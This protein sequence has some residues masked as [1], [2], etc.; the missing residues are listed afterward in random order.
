MPLAPGSMLGPYRLVRLLGAG[1]MGE[2][3]RARDER[4]GRDVAIK[5]LPE[6]VAT[7]SDRLARFER[8]ARATAALD[9]PNILAV[10]DVGRHNGQPY[11]VTQLLE[12]RTLRQAIATG[13]LPVSKALELGIQIAQGLGAAHDRG[14][15]HRDLKPSNIFLTSDGRAKILDFGLARLALSE[16]TTGTLGERSTATDLTLAGAPVGTVGYMAP[17]QV[18]GLPADHRSDIFSFGCVLYEMLAGQRAFSKDS[19]V[20]TMGSILHEDPPWLTASSRSVP[21]ALAAVVRRCLEKRP[22]ARFQSAHD[23][24]LALEALS[25]NGGASF[26]LL[27]APTWRWRRWLVIAAGCAAVAV[28]GVSLN[29]LFGGHPLPEFEPRQVTTRPGLESE[30]AL[31]PLGTDIAYTGHD[32]TRSDIW[33]VDVRGGQ[34]LRLTTDGAAN[35]SPTWFP[36]GSAI[37]YSSQRGDRWSV[38]KV[39]RLGGSPLLVVADGEDPAISPDG[40]TIAFARSVAGGFLRIAVAP[41]GSP[42]QSRLLTGDGDGVYHHRRPAWSR[43]GATICYHDQNDLWLVPAAGGG[44]R[45]LTADDAPDYDPVWSPSGRWVYFASERQQTHAIWRVRVNNG[46]LSR[47]TMGSGRERWPTLAPSGGLLAY[48]TLAERV[49]LELVDTATQVRTRFDP[50]RLLYDPSIAPDRGSVV[51]TSNVEGSFDLWR[52]RL[53]ENRP[54]G[55]PERLTEQGGACSLPSFSC[56]GRWIAFQRVTAGQRDVWTMP[57]EGGVPTNFTDHPAVDINPAWSPDGSR[58][59]FVSN[60][61]GVDQIWISPVLDG[62][63]VGEPT[64]VAGVEGAL[65]I[66][67]WSPDGAWIAFVAEAGTESEVW[68]A[69]TDG[70]QAPRKLTDGAGAQ[71]AAWNF[72]TGDVLV[73]GTW[74]T[75]HWVVRRVDPNGGQAREVPAAAPTESYASLLE[76]DLS[77]D[78]QL[79]ALLVNTT[80][81]DV[82]AL[83]ATTGGF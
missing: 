62:R 79:M 38:W 80:N 13:P 3:Y 78:G 5:V 22:E 75:P 81:G 72:L 4:L 68:V 63:R 50:G 33:V 18:R 17:E 83:E 60:R 61:A 14:I 24:A 36:D 46:E 7:D 71:A 31:S 70:S 48:S 59:A 56:D 11:L 29:R 74:G 66:P 51:F 42:Q 25:S 39:P 73:L 30:P 16:L 65:S 15:I 57:S 77:D 43:D 82:W 41:V 32:G 55:E 28:A 76:F 8:E 12:G 69:S 34:P 9:H 52:L 47:V 27:F 10:Y 21:P 19:A 1:G 23:I 53:H 37:A 54:A 64:P 2:V 6:E 67:T 26:P 58:L 35:R 44:A 49:S 45:R 20:E 40:R